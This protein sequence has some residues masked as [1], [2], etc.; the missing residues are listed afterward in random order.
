MARCSLASLRKIL[1]Y[2]HNQVKLPR[3][4]KSSESDCVKRRMH[5]FVQYQYWCTTGTTA[6]C[7]H[8]VYNM[9][10]CN[11]VRLGVKLTYNDT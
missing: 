2:G 1:S 7:R 11:V 3:C 5:I 10:L 9:S 8:T 4:I 6:V